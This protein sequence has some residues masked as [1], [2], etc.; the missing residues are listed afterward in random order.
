M[1]IEKYVEK[2]VRISCRKGNVL[3]VSLGD[4][5]IDGFVDDELAG[6]CERRCQEEC[7]YEVDGDSV[8]IGKKMSERWGHISDSFRD[9]TRG[10]WDRD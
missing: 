8:R 3:F 10:K 4:D 7:Q 6:Y 2:K 5:Y 1:G 9:I